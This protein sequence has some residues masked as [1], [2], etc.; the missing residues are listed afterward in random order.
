VLTD[1]EARFARLTGAGTGSMTV[2]WSAE[3]AA[4][5]GDGLAPLDD[6]LAYELWLIDAEGVPQPMRLLDPADDGALQRVVEV[7][8][9][10]AAWGVTIE[11]E[12]GS[13]APTT[14]VIYTAAV[15]A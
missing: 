14:D 2:V 12:G 8:G 11:P 10:P 15:T 3:R 7:E 9:R 6:G 4:V 5:I 1:P 13:A